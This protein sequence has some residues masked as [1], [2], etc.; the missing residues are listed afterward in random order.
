M[1]DLLELN[2]TGLFSYGLHRTIKLDNLGVTELTGMNYDRSTN[3]AN[4]CGKTNL[5]NAGTHLLYGEDPLEASDTEI[6]NRVWDHGCWGYLKYKVPQ[7]LFRIVLCRKWTQDYPD[8]DFIIQPA[9]LH[10][11][12]DKYRGTDLYFDK[13][14]GRMWIDKRL[15]KSADTRK[16]ILATLPLSYNQFLTTSYM[17]QTKGISF[18]SGKNKDR[19]QIITELQDLSIWDRGTRVVRDRHTGLIGQQQKL[20]GQIDGKRMAVAVLPQ[21]LSTQ[22]IVNINTQLEQQ[23]I[24]SNENRITITL[25]K[26]EKHELM[27]KLRECRDRVT[28]WHDESNRQMMVQAACIGKISNIEN[29][30]T[31]VMHSMP[32]P[33]SNELHAAEECGRQVMA[34]IAV[35]TKRQQNAITTGDKCDRCGVF[36]TPQLIKAHHIDLGHISSEQHQ[37]LHVTNIEIDR[38][39]TLQFQQI[40]EATK[41]IRAQFDIRRAQLDVDRQTAADQI[42]RMQKLQRQAEQEQIDINRQLDENASEIQRLEIA[43]YDMSLAQQKVQA[44]LDQNIALSQTIVAAQLD[45]QKDTDKLSDITQE[46]TALS[47]VIK[48][49]SD[50]GIKAYKFGAIIATLNELVKEYID[51]LTDRQV[52]VWFTPFREK[53]NAKDD[54]D[55]IP[56]VSIFVREGPKE[57]LELSLYSGAEKQ[58]IT[59]AILCAFWR[60]ATQQGGGCNILFLD[61]IFGSFDGPSASLAVRL[62][63]K[64]R[65]SHFGTIV[66]VTHDSKVKDVLQYDTSWI[67]TKR[68]HIATLQVQ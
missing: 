39:R 66:V 21:P 29:E 22:A 36:L 58:Q 68:S 24:Q 23:D 27:G 34:Q 12:G 18:V 6:V 55:L 51:I 52:Q 44:Q 28:L 25:L 3:T 13:W 63:D 47:V 35:T 49:M 19:M 32:I 8:S 56:E 31:A 57:G 40:D 38:I 65:E 48:G 33:L 4:G 50:R 41:R 14:D 54:D 45:I 20:S 60:L 10:M 61:E 37:V 11:Q 43:N 16:A 64:L 2:P 42:I 7:G 30:L 59:L 67:V 62:I 5:L 53:T 15:A 46:I 9:Q 17:A 26:L 1:L